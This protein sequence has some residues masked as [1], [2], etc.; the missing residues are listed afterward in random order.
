MN[1]D[2][3]VVKVS[4]QSPARTMPRLQQAR[5]LFDPPNKE[6]VLVVYWRGSKRGLFD[7]MV[8]YVAPDNC[9][10]CRYPVRHDYI[11]GQLKPLSTDTPLPKEWLEANCEQLEIMAYR[12]IKRLDNLQYTLRW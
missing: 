3:R 5:I 6:S 9:F 1:K 8:E 10:K 7:A 12:S 4:V 2:I 11:D